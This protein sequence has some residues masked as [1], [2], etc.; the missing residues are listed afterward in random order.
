MG[1][2]ETWQSRRPSRC[3]RK[4]RTRHLVPRSGSQGGGAR[5]WVGLA[6]LSSLVQP[7]RS[8]D[9]G[10]APKGPHTT[11]G[12]ARRQAGDSRCRDSARPRRT[13]PPPP[14]GPAT[15]CWR[16][17]GRARRAAAASGRR[18]S[19]DGSMAGTAGPQT[20]PRRCPPAT[21]AAQG[22]RALPAAGGAPPGPPRQ[23]GSPPAHRAAAAGPAGRGAQSGM[24]KAELLRF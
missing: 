21:G 13:V 4:G 10:T 23:P 18:S 6:G 3:L 2:P 12:R 14:R 24:W 22:G 8:R 5:A 7:D 1:C 17:S 9:A 11:V 15:T 19:T 16:A 20:P